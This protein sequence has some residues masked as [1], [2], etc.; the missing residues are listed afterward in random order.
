MYKITEEQKKVIEKGLLTAIDNGTDDE[1]TS[2][3]MHLINDAFELVN[4][5][6]IPVVSQQRKLLIA[7]LNKTDLEYIHQQGCTDILAEDLLRAINCG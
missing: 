6:T 4:N 3:E 7:E 2:Q 5:L 1:F